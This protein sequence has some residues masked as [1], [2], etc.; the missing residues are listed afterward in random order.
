[1][2][3]A[4]IRNGDTIMLDAFTVSNQREFNA[5]IIAAN[6]QRF[7][8]NIKNVVSADAF[9]DV[10]EGNVGEFVKYLPG[11]TVD[12]VAADVRT[13]S[14][15]GF[16]AQFTNMYQDGLRLVSASSGNLNRIFELE[17]VSINNAA[18]IEVAKVPTPDIGADAR[19]GGHVRDRDLRCGRVQREHPGRRDAGH[20]V[21]PVPG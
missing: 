10:T 1:M 12:Y 9:G 18:R 21:V 8:P 3:A 14:V 13:I 17:Q 2:T 7:A 5:A 11:I 6:E 16:A 15:R 20:A 4:T 19:R